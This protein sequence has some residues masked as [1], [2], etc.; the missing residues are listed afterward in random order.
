M[1]LKTLQTVTAVIEADAGLALLGL[2]SATSLLV[3]GTPLDTAA[4]VS[5]VRVGGPG[6]LALAI[7]SWLARRD[8]HSLASRGLIVAMLFY[9]LAVAGV[10]AFVGLV[11]GLHGVL[12]W[13]PVVF[14]AAMRLVHHNSAEK[15]RRGLAIASE[16]VVRS[17]LMSTAAQKCEYSLGANVFRCIRGKR[18]LAGLS[19]AAGL[20]KDI[21][22]PRRRRSKA[23][24]VSKGRRTISCLRGHPLPSFRTSFL[25]KGH[26]VKCSI[27]AD[28]CASVRLGLPYEAREIA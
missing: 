28:R 5:L 13:P 6:I 19:H 20:F 27:L 3:L 1:T 26:S 2:P 15:G 25:V 7:V 18:T 22:L 12:L 16:R 8:A 4:A 14:Q 10:L 9:N 11:D 21:P 23:R 17:V 24:I